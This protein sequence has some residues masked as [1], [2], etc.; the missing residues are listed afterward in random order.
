MNFNLEELLQMKL[1]I[2]RK[3]YKEC[4]KV[5]PHLIKKRDLA[6]MLKLIHLCKIE[7]QVGKYIIFRL[8]P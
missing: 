3:F 4:R 6:L 2:E 7:Y 1:L 8:K 5:I